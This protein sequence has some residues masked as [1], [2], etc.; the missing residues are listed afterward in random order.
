[1]C[2]IRSELR[3]AGWDRL[4][5][6]LLHFH[7]LYVLRIGIMHIPL[8]LRRALK[9]STEVQPTRDALRGLLHAFLVFV[10]LTLPRASGARVSKTASTHWQIRRTDETG[11]RRNGPPRCPTSPGNR[12]VKT[13]RRHQRN[14]G[15]PAVSSK[16]PSSSSLS[17]CCCH[18]RHHCQ[19]PHHHNDRSSINLQSPSTVHCRRHRLG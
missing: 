19:H 14:E 10:L 4:W 12:Q 18:H 1:M 6:P 5:R 11:C 7:S 17:S 15:C 9:T 2:F 16:A 8:Y 3:I 13:V